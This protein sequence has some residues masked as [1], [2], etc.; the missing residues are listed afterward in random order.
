MKVLQQQL[1]AINTYPGINTALCKLLT[2]ESHNPWWE[3]MVLLTTLDSDLQRAIRKQIE[4]G[5]LTVAKGYLIQEWVDIQNTWI[6]TTN[7][8]QTK[9]NWCK[10][11]ISSIHN[12]VYGTWK[13]RNE[14]VHGKTQ[15][16]KKANEKSELQHRVLVLHNRGRANLTLKEKN[17]FKLP[18]EQRMNRG[19]DSLRLWIKIVEGIF[20]NRGAARQESINNWL[21]VHQNNVFDLSQPKV[22][23][24][25]SEISVTDINNNND[26]EEAS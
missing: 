13:L 9:Y 24:K 16:S 14:V 19:T 11:V 15:K 21:Q 6:R 5:E 7:S 2:H 20:R 23:K 1:R 3:D 17:Y 18:V 8:P 4:L 22:K 10:E 25:R 12:Y 26:G